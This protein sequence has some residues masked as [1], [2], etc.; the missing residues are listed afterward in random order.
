MSQVTGG[1]TEEERDTFC[2]LL[3]RFN[4]SLAAR[5]A[6]IQPAQDS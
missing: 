1:W 4:A 6:A 2:A 3:T 5:Q